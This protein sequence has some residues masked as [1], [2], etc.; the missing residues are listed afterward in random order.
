MVSIDNIAFKAFR[1]YLD[2]AMHCGD[3][4]VTEAYVTRITY[5]ELKSAGAIG[6]G[7]QDS[8]EEYLII[9]ENDTVLPGPRIFRI[10]KIDVIGKSSLEDAIAEMVFPIIFI[11]KDKTGFAI[12]YSKA[13]DLAEINNKRCQKPINWRDGFAVND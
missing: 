12:V 9:R 3:A 8:D 4:R 6:R 13:L 10:G 7:S 11:G 2:V 5:E 1:A